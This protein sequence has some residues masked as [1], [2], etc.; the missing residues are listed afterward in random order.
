MAT[1]QKSRE[2]MSLHGMA[3]SCHPEPQRRVCL[4]GSRDASRGCHPEPQRRVSRWLER[5][6]AALSMTAFSCLLLPVGV[7]LSRSEGSVSL[8]VEMLRCA[9]HESVVF[10]LRHRPLRAFRLLSPLMAIP[11]PHHL[12][13]PLRMVMGNFLG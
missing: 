3:L 7:T 5:Y 6:F 8:G 13:S 11:V 2:R 1:G 4:A 12:P 9:Q 10:L